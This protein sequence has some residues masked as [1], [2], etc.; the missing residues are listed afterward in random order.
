[1]KG[2]T[3]SSGEISGGGSAYRDDSGARISVENAGKYQTQGGV[4]T[5]RGN[6][7]AE[8][9]GSRVTF[10]RFFGNF[11][12]SATSLSFSSLLLFCW[13]IRAKWTFVWVRLGPCCAD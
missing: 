6:R 5:P 10:D 7:F 13:E 1:M 11:I 2:Y 8:F 12:I 4:S 3:T 9:L